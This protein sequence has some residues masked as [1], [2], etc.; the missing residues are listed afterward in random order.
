M[1][2]IAPQQFWSWPVATVGLG[3]QRPLSLRPNCGR[4]ARPNTI[5]ETERHQRVAEIGQVAVSGVG[6][7]HAQFKTSL[8]GY[9]NLSESDLRLGA[10][11]NF[12]RHAC[13]SA[14]LPIVSPLFGQI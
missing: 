12:W 9:L 8:M 14:P 4:L 10:K 13:S 3:R 7:D 11:L 1:F 6:H 5:V 2:F